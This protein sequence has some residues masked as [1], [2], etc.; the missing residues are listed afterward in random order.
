MCEATIRPD[1]NC[2]KHFPEPEFNPNVYM[3]DDLLK[4]LISLFIK[5]LN[6]FECRLMALEKNAAPNSE[7]VIDVKRSIEALEQQVRALRDWVR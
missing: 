6:E 4:G 3:T 2:I 5:R 1:V 7:S